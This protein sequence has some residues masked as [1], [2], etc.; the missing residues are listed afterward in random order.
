[1]SEFDPHLQNAVNDAWLERARAV[2]RKSIRDNLR[3]VAEGYFTEEDLTLALAADELSDAVNKK[4][5]P[6]GAPLNV[7]TTVEPE[8]ERAA[9]RRH[10]A[11]ALEAALDRQA[12]QAYPDLPLE[13]AIEAVI[14]A[15][16][17]K[18]EELARFEQGLLGVLGRHGLL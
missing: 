16:P 17:E 4:P 14:A 9:A 1:M 6:I 13:E 5:L 12:V 18:V 15:N 2:M 11:D 3:L 10:A 8:E 7:S